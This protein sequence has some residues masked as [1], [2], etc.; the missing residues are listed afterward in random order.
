MP[1]QPK[2]K[3]GKMKVGDKVKINDESY[4][5]AL[6]PSGDIKEEHKFGGAYS[7]DDLFVAAMDCVL[8]TG[9]PGPKYGRTNNVLLWNRTKGYYVC[10]FL[11]F[12]TVSCSYNFCPHCGK[13][14]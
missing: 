9:E 8:P 10:S 14:L 1:C 12:L 6:L 11:E 4:C 3:E 2:F 5:M 13:G 7:K